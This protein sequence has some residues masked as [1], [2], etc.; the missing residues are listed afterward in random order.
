MFISRKS[1]IPET[2]AFKCH[3]GSSTAMPI[4]L[5]LLS[6][7]SPICSSSLGLILATTFLLWYGL[8]PAIDLIFLIGLIFLI[9]LT[10][11]QPGPA[12]CHLRHSRLILAR[13]NARHVEFKTVRTP[14]D[15]IPSIPL[16]EP[17]TGFEAYPYMEQFGI[18]EQAWKWSSIATL[19]HCVKDRRLFDGH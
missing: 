19:L 16:R 18:W 9:H 11:F 3:V 5:I 2:L 17:Y 1:M 15:K 12:R 10:S 7:T 8:C 4:W 14:T 6:Y 13:H